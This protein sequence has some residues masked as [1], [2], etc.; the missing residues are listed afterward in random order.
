MRIALGIEYN[1]AEFRGWQVQAG[2]RTV[3]ACLQS[4]LGEVADHPIAVTCAGRT[5][6]GVHALSQVVH[7]DTFAD[8]APRAWLLGT[9]AQLPDDAA[10]V[11]VAPVTDDFN[12][13]FSAVGRSYVYLI[14]NRASRTA[15]FTKAMTWS[16]REL[17]AE[18]MQR[19]AADLVGEH[20]FSS[21][22][23]AG[24]QAKHP[25]RTISH[26]GIE[27]TGEFVIVRIKANAFLQKMVRNIVGVLTAIGTGERPESWAAEVLAHR[28]R[29]LGGVTAPA[30][31]LY[32][33][34]VE[35]PQHYNLPITEANLPLF[36][37]ANRRSQ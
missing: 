11:W 12:A 9:N 25:I 2:Q 1:G 23:A 34:G 32:L 35:Y 8:R 29:E 6:T 10:T 19:A 36:V 20:D 18:R 26:L 37:P 21:F 14:Q 28:S 7:F 33:A 16:Y 31:G 3:Q 13:R 4:A 17:D 15:L 22:Q 27:R 5:D 30:C 24:C